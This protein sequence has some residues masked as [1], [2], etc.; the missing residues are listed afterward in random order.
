ML[1]AALR[2]EMLQKRLQYTVAEVNPL[3]RQISDQFF[4][5]FSLQ[6]TKTLHVFLPIIRYNEINTWYIIHKLQQDYPGISLVVPVTNLK[7]LTLSHY[8]FTSATE[9]AENKWGIL[10]PQYAEPIAESSIDLVLIP[11]LAVDKQG[12]RIGYGKGFYD[13]FLHLCR[14][15]VL[16]IGL[17]LEPPLTKITDVHAGDVLLDFA[18]TPEKVY[19]FRQ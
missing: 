14:P 9:L 7:E 10:E 12:H 16:K 6:E 4:A 19:A 8:L 15:D 3:S 2:K 17:S 1:K 13:R 11:L 18:V 5:F